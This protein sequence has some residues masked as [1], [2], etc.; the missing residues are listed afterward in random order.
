MNFCTWTRRH[1]TG[2]GSVSITSRMTGISVTVPVI[3]FCDCFVTTSDQRIV[4]LQFGVVE[5]LG[6]S[7]ADGLY[8]VTVEPTNG[9]NGGNSVETLP[10][11]SL[12]RG[13]ASIR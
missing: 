2:C 11:T 8:P 6:L 12:P 9:P 4:D 13:N 1:S 10:N 3:D 5:M 7:L